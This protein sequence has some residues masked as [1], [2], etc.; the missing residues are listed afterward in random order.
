[1][2]R[3][4]SLEIPSKND[5]LPG[6]SQR[7]YSPENHFVT[8]APLSECMSEEKP[9]IL[10]GMGCFWGAE[11]IFWDLD[12]VRVTGV[13]YAAGYTQNPTYEEVCS[14]LTAH[15]EIV[16][17]TYEDESNLEELLQVFWEGHDPTQFM[18]QGG[19]VGTQ[20]RSGIYFLDRTQEE[21]ALKTKDI[22]QAKLNAKGFGEIVTEILPVT[23]EFYAED[24][25]QQ[26][27]AKNPN[28][29]CGHGGCGVKFKD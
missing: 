16:F 18:R 12:Y 20:Y 29:Y 3:F 15:S 4:K 23:G 7:I 11:K 17:V 22:Y 19:D 26:Y 14:G 24:Y 8:G 9:R 28:G 1:M 27:L 5:C 25:H 21:L 6:R 13:G 2:L 10:F